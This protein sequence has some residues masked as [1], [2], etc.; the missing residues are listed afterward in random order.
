MF[1]ELQ[2]CRLL[3]DDIRL[4]ALSE[5][6][7]FAPVFD[8][9]LL[10]AGARF[11]PRA[12]RAASA[13]QTPFRGFNPRRGLNP[14]TS[15]YTILDCGDIPIT[16][17]DNALALR[18]MS[19]AFFELGSRKPAILQDSDSSSKPKL[20]TLGGDHSIALP[21]LRALNKIYGGPI[22]VLHFDAHLD[23]W[24]PAKYPSPWKSAQS[25]FNHGSM[26]WIASNEGLILNGSSAH[27]GLR[28]RLSG[29]GWD[30][31][32][33]DE[34]QGFLRISSD[35]IDDLGTKG[36]IDAIIKRIRVDT[37]T[38]L[39]IDI[40]V[41]DPGLCPGTGT[42]EPG[43]WTS[44]ELIR[45]LRGLEDLNVVGADIVEVAPAYDGVGEQTA[46]TAAQLGFEILTSWVGRGLKLEGKGED[47]R[48]GDIGRKRDEL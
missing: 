42:P 25:D 40:D 20:L 21:A 14:Y 19:E 37:P 32:V 41:I 39:S 31:F 45:I 10:D 12:I 5:K 28:T 26:F 24:H 6:A 23:T 16:P 44:R 36:I 3:P 29:D 13:R 35:D 43:G 46:L 34:R 33:D 30:D 2:A 4:P 15:P 48:I 17:F 1:D 18:Q 8:F 9:L 11:G 27:A 22:A 38:Y 47:G 7:S